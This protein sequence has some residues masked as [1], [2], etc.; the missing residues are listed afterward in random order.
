M[1][2]LICTKEEHFLNSQNVSKDHYEESRCTKLSD[3]FFSIL[4]LF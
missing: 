3:N 1:G 2:N 4:C